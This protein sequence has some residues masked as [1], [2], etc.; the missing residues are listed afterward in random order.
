MTVAVKELM[1]LSVYP[2]ISLGQG[3][4]CLTTDVAS[5]KER[6]FSA[7]AKYFRKSGQHIWSTFTIWWLFSHW[8]DIR[9]SNL[10]IFYP[11]LVVKEKLKC[12]LGFFFAKQ[13]PRMALRED[14]NWFKW[15]SDESKQCTPFYGR[16]FFPLYCE[17]EV[18]AWFM[19]WSFIVQVQR[20]KTWTFKIKTLKC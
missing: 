14:S 15:A 10:E 20:P 13:R 9:R 18:V 5:G 19:V 11:I 4:G 3:E 1:H 8:K 17:K 6:K 12:F 16:L 2:S 7:I